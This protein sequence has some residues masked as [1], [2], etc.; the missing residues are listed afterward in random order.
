[1]R[2][3]S[4]VALCSTVPLL[5]VASEARTQSTP[6]LVADRAATAAPRGSTRQHFRIASAILG[7]TRRIGISPPASFAAS[8]P[9]RRYPTI[10]VLDGEASLEPMSTVADELARNGQVPEAVI[11]AIENTNRLRDLTPPGLSVS[12]ST[13]HEG[14]D[15][16]LDF[17]EKE[18]LPAVDRQFRAAAPRT[19]VGH[20]SGGILATY[21][22]AT[23]STY[24]AVVALDTP[25]EL[26]DRWLIAKLAAREGASPSPL[27]YAALDARFPFPDDAWRSL[28][29]AAPTTWSLFHEHLANESHESMPMLGMYLGLREVFA[30]YSMLHAPVS[31]TTS[32]LPYYAKAS[33]SLGASVPP[34]RK[35]LL[36]VIEDLQMEGGG[37]QRARRTTHSSWRTA[38]RRMVQRSRRRSP[39]SSVARLRQRRW[40][41]SSRHRSRRRT[42]CVPISVNGSGAIG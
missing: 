15:R 2:L 34:P 10:V 1:M 20:S 36:N 23:R 41:R 7:E 33:A 32:I 16:F 40:S 4:L 35:L 5:G 31:P 22:A 26:G 17:I 3:R 19:L 27:R 42:R 29:A 6:A 12:G 9:S 28:V 37:E 38:R 13:T 14:G 24:R 39:T 18:L 8:A 30:D 11:V 25:V 21:A